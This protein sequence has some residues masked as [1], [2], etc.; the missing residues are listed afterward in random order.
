LSDQIGSR[1][2]VRLTARKN[3]SPESVCY[4]SR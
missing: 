4:P 2:T 3:F 1:I